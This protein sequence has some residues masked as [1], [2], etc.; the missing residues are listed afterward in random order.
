MQTMQSPTRGGRTLLI[1]LVAVMLV[2]MVGGGAFAYT[3]L[4]TGAERA[5]QEGGSGSKAGDE[6]DGEDGPVTPAPETTVQA[7]P[8]LTETVSA[9][10]ETPSAISASSTAP[11][12]EDAG[13]REHTYEPDNAID[14]IT[15]TAW[16]VEEDSTGEYLLL[17]YDE[18]VVVT[19][20]GV[21]P[22][23]DKIDPFD[24]TDRFYQRHVVEEAEIEFSDGSSVEAE[25]DQ[26]PKMQFTQVPETETEYVRI[27]ILDTYP[28][29]ASPGADI[30]AISE[31]EVEGP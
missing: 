29:D 10:G 3:T 28:P 31:I 5:G 17:E 11:P 9:S 16:Q 23:Y 24:G 19:S 27:T 25:F 26:D 30:A 18:P 2:L 7:S 4:L 21:I 14:G 8:P 20:V 15:E 22:G 13:G 12:Q 6:E 1:A